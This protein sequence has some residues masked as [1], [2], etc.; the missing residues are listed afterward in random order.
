MKRGFTLIELLLVISIIGLLSSVILAAFNNAKKNAQFARAGSDMYSLQQAIELEYD[1]TGKYPYQDQTSI[2]A[3]PEVIKGFYDPEY[4]ADNHEMD[5]LVTNK[6]I[7]S[8]PVPPPNSYFEYW[9]V[10][11]NISRSKVGDI[12]FSC[13]T[14]DIK[15][16]AIILYSTV[17]PPGFKNVII[18]NI[19]FF[20][21]DT[22]N[23][24][25]NYY[26]LNA[27]S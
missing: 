24:Y 9:V 7:P 26:C 5:F 10:N 12:W 6:E 13:D 23:I 11:P 18:H 1:K 14:E 27:R 4:P 8:F 22:P 3:R 15:S 25:N 19:Q 16:Y 2:N 17:P 20:M 21:G